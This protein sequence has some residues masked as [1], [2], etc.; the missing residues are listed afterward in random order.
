MA[1][2]AYL[3]VSSKGQNLDS[4]EDMIGNLDVEFEPRF[5]FEE[6]KSGRNFERPVYQAM[7]Q[8]MRPGDVLYVRALNR[9]GRNADEIKKEWYDIHYIRQVHIVVLDCQLLD[10]RD[11]TNKGKIGG[12]VAEIA[13]AILSHIAEEE[14]R[15]KK[16]L[17][18]Q[19]IEAAKKRGKHLGRPSIQIDEKAFRA[20]ADK[21]LAGSLSATSAWRYLSLS[22]ATFYRQAK[23]L[24]YKFSK[25]ISEG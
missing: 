12:L 24:G 25:E 15:E 5:I 2:I 10:T 4:Q 7:K 9:L 18:M 6:K 16:E 20:C 1:N 19:G 21:V 11:A 3:R 14:L 22:K 17:Q 23:K 13:L 8:V